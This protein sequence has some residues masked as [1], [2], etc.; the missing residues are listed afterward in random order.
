MLKLSRIK[1]ILSSRG[2]TLP[3]PHTIFDEAR[4]EYSR[5]IPKIKFDKLA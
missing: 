5:Y 2:L 1:I 3:L 4:I